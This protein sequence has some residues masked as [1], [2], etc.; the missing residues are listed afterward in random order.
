MSDRFIQKILIAIICLGLSFRIVNLF[1]GAPF[2]FHPDERNIASAIAGL[3]FPAQLNPNF[4]AYGS[5]PIYLAFFIGMGKNILFASSGISL[6]KV[7]FEDAIII[8]RL[9][10]VILSIGTIFLVYKIGSIIESKSVGLVAAF[11]SATS[12][13][14]IQYAHFGTFETWL[15]FFSTLLFYSLL[16]YYKRPR[17]EAIALI[18]FSL[19]VL[20]S[21]KISSIIYIPLASLIFFQKHFSFKKKLF[22]AISIFSSVAIFYIFTNP[23]ALLD[24][25]S[26]I[27]SITYES[28]VALGKLLVFYTGE[29]YTSIPI[30][31][32]LIKIYPFLL[33]PV[34][35]M[36]LPL[37]L[38]I[39][40]ITLLKKFS[41]PIAFLIIFF[42]LSFLSQ[43][44]LFAQW[45][46]YFIP[47]LP[48]I[49]LII[50]LASSTI[51][52]E[53]AS[54]KKV[55]NVLGLMIFVACLILA[56]AFVKTVY[57]AKDTRV[58]AA[59]FASRN[60]PGNANILSEVYDL[61]IVPFNQSFQNITLFNFYDL[62]N[63]SPDATTKILDDHLSRSDYLILP[64]QRLYQTRLNDPINF[65]KGHTI[66]RKIHESPTFKKIYETPCDIW[67]KIT[68]MYNPI[69]GFEQTANIFDRPTVMIFKINHEQKN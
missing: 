2:F 40:L 37:S 17:L 48:F 66:Y 25:T 22:S 61:G 18:C 14:L 29:F 67:C 50:A 62:D 54:Y 1:W 38:F 47:S 16:S 9:F 27:N 41:K 46:R 58:T 4:F 63:D 23:F 30:V 24:Q 3:N 36:L 11:L 34:I 49:Y 51:Y 69:F 6:E 20:I 56:F 15:A 39:T 19:S 42:L 55:W 45:T 5:L 64:S 26:F 60:I 31:F 52:R 8:L 33:N 65:P 21:V 53:H 59:E 43:T 68:Y 44:F 28:N 35:F 57:L 13:G 7:N 10:S 32:P 12:I